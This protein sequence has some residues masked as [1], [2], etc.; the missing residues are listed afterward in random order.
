MILM[1]SGRSDVCAH[2]AT[3]FQHRLEAGFVDVRNP[4]YKTQVSRIYFEDVKAIVFCTK[5]PIPILPTLET[6]G[7]PYLMQV[8]ITPYGND[9]EVNVTNKK[10]VIEAVKQLA[11]QKGKHFVSVRY[12]PIFI[13]DKY[14]FAYHEMMFER[15]CEQLDGTIATIIISFLDMKKNTQQYQRKY[16]LYEMSEQ[17]VYAISQRLATIATKYHIALQTCGEHYDLTPYGI[18]NES[19]INTK[20]INQLRQ[21]NNH[22]RKGNLREHCD[23]IQ[24]VDIGAYNSC[25][26]YCRYCYAN[27]EEAKVM[28]NSR[29]HNPESTL[30]IGELQ[31]ED[32]VKRR[33]K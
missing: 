12:D 29:L 7:I 5:N 22:Y 10:A 33:K 23:C 11:K 16:G 31:A 26:H 4:F 13:N 2:Y 32:V 15:L 18:T 25:T 3:W 17:Q 19:C 1:V 20:I 30:L 27:Y 9:I 28:R 14:N 6:L 24:S 21:E 8:S